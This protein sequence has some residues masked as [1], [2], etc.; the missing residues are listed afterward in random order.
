[1]NVTVFC[2]F[3]SY[4][5]A[6]AAESARLARAWTSLRLLVIGFV[7]AG[8]C[9]HTIYLVGE[10][11]DAGLPPLLSSPRDWILV[12]AWV[13]SVGGFVLAVL[14]DRP[15]IGIFL[16]PSVLA[17]IGAALLTHDASG[18]SG[19]A[20]AAI[21]VATKRWAI[22]H[23]A[24]IL[25]GV[26]AVVAGLSSSLM[27]LAQ[28]RRLKS[29]RDTPVTAMGMFS[30]EKLA[31]FNRVAITTAVV[32]LAVGL[33]AGAALGA[34]TARE[35]SAGVWLDPLVVSGIGG[36]AALC[37]YLLWMLRAGARASGRTVAIRTALV[38]GL[39]IATLVGLQI[40]TGGRVSLSSWHS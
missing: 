22:A 31:L 38:C 18:A 10:G 26:A 35:A 14:D 39:L 27:Y 24:A 30:L 2:F 36:W 15:A 37:G 33:A 20:A 21:G 6:F 5:V 13:M 29:K 4:V 11:N 34:L 17:L 16:I 7:G 25:L 1:M 40:L 19:S 23:A 3:A 32:L 9:A 8:L 28:H 12:L